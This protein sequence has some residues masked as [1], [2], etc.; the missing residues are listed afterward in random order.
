[1]TVDIEE[2]A[3]VNSGDFVDPRVRGACSSN[4]CGMESADVKAMWSA[5][6]SGDEAVLT[7]GELL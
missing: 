7:M 1:M 6:V 2:T 4:D 3:V 5:G